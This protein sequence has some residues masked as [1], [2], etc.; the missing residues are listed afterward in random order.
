MKA[1]TTGRDRKLA[2]LPSRKMA[3]RKR[4]PLESRASVPAAAMM[5]AGLSRPSDPIAAA[6][7][8]ETTATGPTASTRLEPNRA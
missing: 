5:S 3:N 4:K 6:V 2:T 8:K 1:C 7:I